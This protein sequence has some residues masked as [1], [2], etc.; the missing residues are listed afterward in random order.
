VH[1]HFEQGDGGDAHV[2]EVIWVLFPWLGIFGF[3]LFL[4]IKIVEGIAGWVNELNIV[5]RL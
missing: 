5:V 4:G 2:F 1:D 3:L